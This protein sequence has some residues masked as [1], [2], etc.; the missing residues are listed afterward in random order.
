MI[1]V[2]EAFNTFNHPQ[3]FGANQESFGSRLYN[4][5]IQKTVSIDSEDGISCLEPIV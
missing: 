4:L 1:E 3:L 2:I 5:S